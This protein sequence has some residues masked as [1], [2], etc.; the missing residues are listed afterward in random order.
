M[1]AA[2]LLFSPTTI[3]LLSLA[4][5][6]YATLRSV[7]ASPAT[8]ARKPTPASLAE[9]ST[10][11]SSALAAEKISHQLQKLENRLRMREQREAARAGSAP[12]TGATKAE[13]FR[14]YGFDQVGPRFAQRQL[15]LERA[16]KLNGK[17]D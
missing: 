14:H 1:D 11:L 17:G 2:A 5:A 8:R 6:G 12:P 13:L 10:E 9:S 7:R 15:D 3:A 4:L 16:S